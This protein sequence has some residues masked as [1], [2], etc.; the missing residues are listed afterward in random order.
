MLLVKK[1]LI[2]GKNQKT[3]PTIRKTKIRALFS[4]S[5]VQKEDLIF[6]CK[7]N[8]FPPAGG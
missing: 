2:I 5:L 1:V 3:Q 7:G 6:T 8:V 4:Q